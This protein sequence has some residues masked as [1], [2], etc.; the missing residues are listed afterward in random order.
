MLLGVTDEDIRSCPAYVQLLAA[1][2]RGREYLAS[3]RREEGG[4]PIVTKPADA[5]EIEG[6]ERQYALA[7]R[8]ESLW[9]MTLPEPK[10]ADTL[11]KM[12]PIFI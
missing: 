1:N 11:T 3:R 12:K 6:S 5:R 2:K 4:L 7:C 9:C 8:S 10:P